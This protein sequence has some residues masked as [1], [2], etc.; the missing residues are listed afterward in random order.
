MTIRIA[1]HGDLPEMQQLFYDTITFVNKKDYNDDQIAAWA[2]HAKDVLTWESKLNAQYFLVVEE[3]N[4]ISGFASIDQSG[5]LD[6]LFIHKNKQGLGLA[7]A[8]LNCIEEWAKEHLLS[9][10]WS[11][12]SITAKPFFLR[13][14]FTIEK[15]YEKPSGT[16]I[17]N[18]TIMKK[19]LQ[20]D[21]RS[22]T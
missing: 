11:D 12:V 14:G 20:Y 18:N 3:F 16:L 1:A 17:Y 13:R 19:N 4:S 7:T 8:L 9:E 10:I 15:E 5:C 22:G 2:A 6:Y 21:Q